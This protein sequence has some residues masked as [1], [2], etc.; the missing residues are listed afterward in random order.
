MLDLP[1]K[2]P[3]QSSRHCNIIPEISPGNLQLRRKLAKVHSRTLLFFS[4]WFATVAGNFA[5]SLADLG[6]ADCCQKY[7]KW[8]YLLQYFPSIQNRQWYILAFQIED[9][10]SPIPILRGGFG[11]S[12]F[13]HLQDRLFET[14]LAAPPICIFHI[15]FRPILN[16]LTNPCLW[17]FQKKLVVSVWVNFPCFAFYWQDMV[18]GWVQENPKLHIFV[19]VFASCRSSIQL[20][21]VQSCFKLEVH[22]LSV[23]FSLN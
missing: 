2:K 9:I 6:D 18:S 12:L 21:I 15:L 8:S 14:A 3:S 5:C 23:S 10:P 13:F 16:I 4:R 7:H 20:N 19:P 11:S 17:C 1:R 22:E